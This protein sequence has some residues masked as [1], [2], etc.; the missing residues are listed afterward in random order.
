MERRGKW[1]AV[2]N[3]FVNILDFHLTLPS[4]V[5]IIPKPLPVGNMTF[6]EVVYFLVKDMI[7]QIFKINGVPPSYSRLVKLIKKKFPVHPNTES[8][9]F[10]ADLFPSGRVPFPLGLCPL[11]D[12]LIIFRSRSS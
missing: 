3:K 12:R 5:V 7:L 1:F 8:V 9:E 11:E 6:E 4:G 2:G 10:L